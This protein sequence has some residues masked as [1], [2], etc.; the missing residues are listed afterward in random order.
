MKNLKQ[1]NQVK[2]YKNLTKENQGLFEAFL[3]KYYK[4]YEYPEDHQPIGV[5]TENGYLKVTFENYWLHVKDQN[6][7]Y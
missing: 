2:G 4:G 3:S 1:P 6:T 5:K 7:W